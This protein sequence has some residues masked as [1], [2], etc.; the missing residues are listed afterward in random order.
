MWLDIDSSLQTNDSKWLDSSSD[1]TLTRPSHDS[2][3]TRLEKILDDSDSTM[4]RGSHDSDSTKWLEHI[5]GYGHLT[6]NLKRLIYTAHIKKVI[7]KLYFFIL[8]NI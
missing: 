6:S 2:T 4:T 8:R 5:T 1:S 3:L 7:S